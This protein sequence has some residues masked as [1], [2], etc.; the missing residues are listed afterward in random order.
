MCK[1]YNI[2]YSNPFQKSIFLLTSVKPCRTS[3]PTKFE[4]NP[5]LAPTRQS[6]TFNLVYLV[7]I[8]KS[9]KVLITQ[10]FAIWT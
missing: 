6:L 7:Y 9:K 5:K 10:Y 3:E 8:N 4:S 1:T 2:D